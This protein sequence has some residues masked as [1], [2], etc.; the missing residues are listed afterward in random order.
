MQKSAFE[1]TGLVPRSII[2]TFDRFRRQLLPGAEDLVIQEFRVSK[3]QVLV[4]V[5]CLASLLFFPLLVN[6]LVKTTLLIPLAEYIWNTQQSEIFL[7]FYQENRAFLEM[8]DFEEKTFFES[9]VSTKP[10]Q[11]ND[12]TADKMQVLHKTQ[13]SF[14]P[15]R[16][17]H[18]ALLLAKSVKSPE[19]ITFQ[20][21]EKNYSIVS[22]PP[23]N[24]ISEFSSI[25]RKDNEI[26]L[27][28]FIFSS[29]SKLNRASLN[30]LTKNSFF[31]ENK[32]N[33][34]QDYDAEGTIA[35]GQGF[36]I[37]TKGKQK[38]ET[39][40]FTVTKNGSLCFG[41]K[42]VFFSNQENILPILSEPENLTKFDFVKQNLPI[43][44]LNCQENLCGQKIHFLSEKQKNKKFF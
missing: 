26:D 28:K 24:K 32:T 10:K 20:P 7:N 41:K 4:S 21:V 39:T 19:K 8:R 9:L 40:F 44:Y 30:F 27:E 34:I 18:A 3:Y 38:E 12:D 13:N 35:T 43:A 31:K 37:P 17:Q 6:Y 15:I 36:A 22:L 1:R 2:R 16:A 42:N 29:K 23:K 25:K 14:N 5:R 11:S 33:E